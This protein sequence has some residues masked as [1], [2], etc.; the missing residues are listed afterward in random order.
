MR[1]CLPLLVL[2]LAGCPAGRGP[3]ESPPAAQKVTFPARQG[4]GQGLLFAGRAGQAPRPA[5]VVLHGDY[6]LTP[7]IEEN[8]QRI[9]AL[10][11]VVLAVDLYRG[12]KVET[13]LDAHIMDRGL[14]DERVKGDLKGAV[15][16]L[17][18]RDDV[19]PGAVGVVGWDMGGG[20]AL[21]AA[22]ADPRLRAV[23]TCY[24]RLT[25]DPA[26][27]AP[28]KASVLGLYA[29]LDE[30]NPPGTLAAFRKAMAKAG[31]RLAGLHV[32]EGAA[33]G[34]MNPAPDAKP[35][36]ADEKARED[37]W[38]RIEEYLAAELR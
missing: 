26:L 38:R 6:G 1:R 16:Y 24:G 13:L 18:S 3:E 32:Y 35:T 30:G 28:M 23:V 27:L 34:F 36:A 9:S 33:H 7:R 19:R 17:L 31:K 21:D 14:P 15:D 10:G 29:G 20:Y 4:S 5:V 8:A 2:F 25:T 22:I 37:G 12:E 11:Y